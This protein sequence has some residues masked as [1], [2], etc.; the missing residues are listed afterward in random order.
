D[1]E[2]AAIDC[3]M[4][5]QLP[6]HVL[7]Q[8]CRHGKRNTDIAAARREDGGVHAD[9][10]A[11]EIERRTA[12]IAAVHSR[13]DLEIVVWT[14]ADVA[15]MR[16]DNAGSDRSAETERIADREHPIANPGIFLGEVDERELLAVC[17]HLD[18]SDVGTRIG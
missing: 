3:A 2:P 8:S 11:V 15:I 10:L 4:R 6:D 18:Q 9:H 13:I 16:G 17:L 1:A 14:G 12:G 5:L 7:Y